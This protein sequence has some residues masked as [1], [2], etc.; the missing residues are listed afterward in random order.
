MA[1]IADLEKYALVRNELTPDDFEDSSA[2]KLFVMIEECFKENSLSF[3]TLL[4]HCDDENLSNLITRAVSLGEFRDNTESAV[5][6]SVML[7][8]S[9]S[10]ERQRERLMEQIRSFNC[11]TEDDKA[12]FQKLLSK[13]IE[14]DN[15][16]KSLKN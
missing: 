15:K 14:L 6:D 3:T 11:L 16:I 8:K 10:I 1:I 13:K 7:L 2:R 4:N 9:R 12:E 5:K